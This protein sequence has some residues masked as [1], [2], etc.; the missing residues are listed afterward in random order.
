MFADEVG[1]PVFLQPDSLFSSLWSTCNE[2]SEELLA[3]YRAIQDGVPAIPLRRSA[4][5]TGV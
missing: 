3:S 5:R 1:Y 4:N 2:T